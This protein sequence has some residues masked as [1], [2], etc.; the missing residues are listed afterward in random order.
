MKSTN[1]NYGKIAQ[2]FHW[3]SAL[4]IFTML[5]MGFTMINIADGDTKTTLY[6]IH[7]TIGL[8]VL[9]LTIF[10]II[11]SFIDQKPD[12]LPDMP[13]WR[14]FVF[15]AVHVLLYALPLVLAFS[16]I[17]MLLTAELGISPANVS[18]EAISL[19]VSQPNLHGIV[20]MI[21]IALLLAHIGGIMSYQM[22]KSDTLSRM[23]IT[24][25]K[26]KQ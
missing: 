1:L 6:S 25:L 4:L 16:G 9:A 7:V 3:I 10:R 26:T 14:E 11:W 19:V 5:P 12:M 2:A 20:S 13:P 24:W 21:Y 17:K 15:K 8:I 22:T 18:P 23:G